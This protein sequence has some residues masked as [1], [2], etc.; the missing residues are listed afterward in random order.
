MYV[1]TVFGPLVLIVYGSIMILKD[2]L[3]LKAKYR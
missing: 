2:K 3:Q 1:Y